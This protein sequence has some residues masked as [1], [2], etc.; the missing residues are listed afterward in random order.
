M[1]ENKHLSIKP[2]LKHGLLTPIQDKDGL[3]FIDPKDRPTNPKDLLESK[4][5]A[6]KK[7]EKKHKEL[8]DLT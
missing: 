4:K 1:A 5:A 2:L 3:Q 7:D 8:T 6:L